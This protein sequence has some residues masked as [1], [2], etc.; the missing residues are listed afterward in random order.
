MKKWLFRSFIMVLLLAAGGSAYLF[1]QYGKLLAAPPTAEMVQ[2]DKTQSDTQFT[3]IIEKYV[4]T[5][6]AQAIKE[7]MKT[8][9]LLNLTTESKAE[10]QTNP[11]A[12]NGTVSETTKN[13]SAKRDKITMTSKP[14]QQ[15]G[16][17]IRVHIDELLNVKNEFDEKLSAL[18]EKAKQDYIALPAESHTTENKIKMGLKYMDKAISL[19]SQADAEIY[20]VINRLERELKK[21]NYDTS[22]IK[23]IKRYYEEQKELQRNYFLSKLKS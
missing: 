11:A 16:D 12:K 8:D 10:S 5:E 1:N 23:E 2:I 17:L 13:N 7:E 19:E 22:V 9:L 3:S 15:Q 20:G 18:V 4:G 6:Y 21:N 14:G